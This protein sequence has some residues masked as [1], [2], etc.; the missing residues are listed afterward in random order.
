MGR[1]QVL[2]E[3][4][5]NPLPKDRQRIDIHRHP[6]Y[7]GLRNHIIDFLVS[8]SK[9][10]TQTAVNHDRGTCRS[11]ARRC[12]SPPSSTSPPPERSGAQPQHIPGGET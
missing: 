6:H 2:A 1:A 12:L 4:L 8:R 7:Y 3:I 9:T 11:C 10:F 5:E